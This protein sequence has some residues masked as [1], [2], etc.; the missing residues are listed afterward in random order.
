MRV[1]PEATDVSTSLQDITNSLNQV[2][3]FTEFLHIVSAE[4]LGVSAQLTSGSCARGPRQPQTVASGE[5]QQLRSEAA[6]K[7]EQVSFLEHN[8]R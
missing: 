1:F 3:T 2:D 8:G 7:E 5:V 6:K 4:I